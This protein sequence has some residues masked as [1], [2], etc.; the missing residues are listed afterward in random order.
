MTGIRFTVYGDA[1]PK[2]STRAFV[3]KGWTR[4]IVTSDNP[5]LKSWEQ[6]IRERLQVV[7]ADTERELLDRLFEGPVSVGL[8]FHLRRPASLPKRVT[9]HGKKPDLD[10][11]TRGAIDALSGVLFRDDA[12]VTAIR[13][14]KIYAQSC[15]MV[16][17]DI[18]KAVL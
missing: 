16:E 17:I 6:T 8:V 12:L 13:A 15:A 18:Q 11:L 5:K 2:G 3:P 9:A 14:Q 1:Q 7:M 4:P 10:K